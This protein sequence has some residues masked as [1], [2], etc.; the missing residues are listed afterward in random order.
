MRTAYIKDP[1]GKFAGSIGQGRDRVPAASRTAMPAEDNVIADPSAALRQLL[2]DLPAVQIRKPVTCLVAGCGVRPKADPYRCARHCAHR[3]GDDN[4]WE[5]SDEA[6]DWLLAPEQ[7]HTEDRAL[8]LHQNAV[9]ARAVRLTR[10]QTVRLFSDERLGCTRLEHRRWVPEE[11]LF[12]YAAASRSNRTR[13]AVLHRG[14]SIPLPEGVFHTLLTDADDNLRAD[15]GMAG[16]NMP[17]WVRDIL[18]TDS[19]DRV[20]GAALFAYNHKSAIA[21]DPVW[22]QRSVDLLVTCPHQYWHLPVYQVE[23]MP[24][25]MFADLPEFRRHQMLTWLYWHAPTRD[26]AATAEVLI[27]GRW[28]GSLAEALTAAELLS[29]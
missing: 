12:A 16:N 21:Y 8:Y 18:I 9:A 20:A 13:A 3:V 28:D 2:A 19:S 7:L 6:I 22:R 5:Y 11:M 29:A 26:L 24:V 15:L 17:H 10:D 1:R 4:D 23:D 25:S 14:Q 27:N